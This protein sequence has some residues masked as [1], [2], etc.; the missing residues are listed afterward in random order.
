MNLKN[1]VMLDMIQPKVDTNK[2]LTTMPYKTQK[3]YLQ[4]VDQL[5][6]EEDVRDKVLE[7]QTNVGQGTSLTSVKASSIETQTEDLAKVQYCMKLESQENS[8][9]SD[10]TK[11]GLRELMNMGFLDF[12]KNKNLL[13][14]NVD[15]VD[16]AVSK[17][18][19]MQ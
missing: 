19:Q 6:K 11:A 7:S 2:G 17:M 1:S 9:L 15:N 3:Q 18:F 13:K 16:L 5:F 10:A 12:E 8:H 14:E 4:E